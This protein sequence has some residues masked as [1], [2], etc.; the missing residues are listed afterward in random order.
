M[1]LSFINHLELNGNDAYN[2]GLSKKN[3]KKVLICV[4]VCLQ[5][6]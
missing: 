3:Q 1:C 5:L 2:Y 6:T 4:Y